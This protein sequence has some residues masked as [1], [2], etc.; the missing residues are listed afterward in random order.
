MVT[1]NPPAGPQSRPVARRRFKPLG[2]MIADLVRDIPDEE[3]AKFL[4]DGAAN[5]GPPHLRYA[6]AALIASRSDE[7]SANAWA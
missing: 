2:Q 6:Q 7:L 4:R 1:G 3:M 5:H